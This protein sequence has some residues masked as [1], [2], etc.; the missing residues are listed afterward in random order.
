MADDNLKSRI[1]GGRPA[2]TVIQLVVASIFVGALLALF[3]LSPIRFWQGIFD[4]V[5][6]LLSAIGESFGEIIGNLATYLLLGAA[7]VIPVWL[8]ARLLSGGRRK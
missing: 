4:S 7:I 3:D 1:F 8:V 5:R 2:R 6:G